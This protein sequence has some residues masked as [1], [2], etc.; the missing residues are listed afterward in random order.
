MRKF[1]KI[2]IPLLVL[3]LLVGV[4]AVMA[5]AE[6]V[7]QPTP[8]EINTSA[9]GTQNTNGA[10]RPTSTNNS[11]VVGDST[12]NY[13]LWQWNGFTDCNASIWSNS[14]KD[15]VTTDGSQYIYNTRYVVWSID[16]STASEMPAEF[17][18]HGK[19][20]TWS[21]PDA[22][23]AGATGWYGAQN[24]KTAELFPNAK[25]YEWHN[26]AVVLDT[27][28]NAITA[29]ADGNAVRTW[30][31]VKN[32]IFA[33]TNIQ[34][35][36]VNWRS[37][38]AGTSLAY[39]NSVTAT[40]SD[41]SAMLA[42]LA[43]GTYDSFADADFTN[44]GHVV[45][46][47]K[48]LSTEM[49][50]VKWY[51]PDGTVL[52]AETQVEKGGVAIDPIGI[53]T[54]ATEAN[55]TTA[56]TNF[57][58]NAD[59]NLYTTT[60]LKMTDSQGAVTFYGAET[61]DLHSV[62]YNAAVNATA[63][64]FVNVNLASDDALN[65][66]NGVTVRLWGV[67]LTSNKSD[68]IT[69]GN[70]FTFEGV[71]TAD[72]KR[73]TF[74]STVR[75]F[76][77]QSANCRPTF[78]NLHINFKDIRVGDLRNGTYTFENCA[79]DLGANGY[80]DGG[81]YQSNKQQVKWFFIDS[82]VRV[83]GS[84]TPFQLSG[85]GQYY[86]PQLYLLGKTHIQT[87]SYTFQ[88]D[89]SYTPAEDGVNDALI[90][91]GKDVT[92]G[93]AGTHMFNTSTAYTKLI[94][95]KGAWV[96]RDPAV[97]QS[98]ANVVFASQVNRDGTYVEAELPYT[99]SGQDKTMQAPSYDFDGD[100]VSDLTAQ[101]NS[102]RVLAPI[103]TKTNGTTITYYHTAATLAS[104][105]KSPANGD[106]FD[107]Y[108]DVTITAVELLA[109][110]S[111]KSVTVN[112]HGITLTYSGN[113]RLLACSGNV[114]IQGINVDGKKAKID[115][116]RA[117]D[118]MMPGV[119]DYVLNLKNLDIDL[120][121][122][123]CDWRGGTLNIDGCNLTNKAGSVVLQVYVRGTANIN[124]NI[125]GSTLYGTQTGSSGTIY[126]TRHADGTGNYTINIDNS[127]IK[128]ACN[129]AITIA[130]AKAGDAVNLGEKTN[131]II[132]DNGRAGFAGSGN[133][134]ITIAEG[135]KYGTNAI[136]SASTTLPDG[137]AGLF[138]P[139]EDGMFVYTSA[140]NPN[141]V[142]IV[143]ND[144]GSA[145]TAGL[146]ATVTAAELVANSGTIKFFKDVTVEA[147][148]T[149]SVEKD[150]IFNLNGTTMTFVGL[151][152][153]KD[154]TNRYN[155]RNGHSLAF[156]NGTVD[157][158][159]LGDNL[160]NAQ[161]GHIANLTFDGVK[162]YVAST[163]TDFRASG[164]IT[165]KDSQITTSQKAGNVFTLARG[166]NAK[167]KV[168]VDGSTIVSTNEEFRAPIFTASV[169]ATFNL[170]IT[171]DNSTIDAGRGVPFAAGNE[172][173]TYVDS[174][175]NITV[176][177][178]WI[179]SGSTVLVNGGSDDYRTTI[180]LGEG[181]YANR[182]AVDRSIDLAI[183]KGYMLADSDLEGYDYMVA[184]KIDVVIKANL[185]LYNTITFNVY[186]PT[187]L[188]SINGIARESL[189]M[190]DLDKDGVDDHYKFEVVNL[191]ADAAAAKIAINAVFDVN[192]TNYYLNTN[193]SVVNY[194]VQA[195]NSATS[196]ESRNLTA[197]VARYIENAYLF[198]GK[199]TTELDA[200]LTN[201]NYVEYVKTLTDLD[202]NVTGEKLNIGNITDAF[203]NVTFNL[204]EGVKVRFT[205][206]SEYNGTFKIN[207]ESYTVENGMYGDYNFVEIDI[208]AFDF[209]RNGL[210][211]T[212]DVS[213]AWNIHNYIAG[214]GDQYTGETKTL[215]NA[216]Y[217]YCEA[218][219]VYKTLQQQN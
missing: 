71:T 27:T 189:E 151:A 49:C 109:V 7:E 165:I 208:R 146:N 81:W 3:A 58:V 75:L 138:I 82:I 176:N 32:P 26:F 168:D 215:V 43:N 136:S 210:R 101:T 4:F 114:T 125:T 83:T 33:L 85:R 182:K 39:T 37:F 153:G 19:A 174:Y 141:F 162:L 38:A 147:N 78:K 107:I 29:F 67:E 216:L 156:T 163:I 203:D 97:V 120:N 12:V 36:P 144:N 170:D 8:S 88:T 55:G 122:K 196:E 57:T 16:L 20:S 95:E 205:L 198:S 204:T 72:G 190:V 155:I 175:F 191:A 142:Y 173:E 209:A 17:K 150:V 99:F 113:G 13:T 89:K 86:M 123:L 149:T 41:E 188:V 5:F 192:G 157:A 111:E 164:T 76:N 84:T 11:Y 117:G 103:A 148:G 214:L 158:T 90:V 121:E 102:Y 15:V 131:F 79:I 96:L 178:S 14:F 145:I 60:H 140:N 98:K 143:Y 172:A 184:E 9:P 177:N 47:S 94:L 62:F 35:E 135:F 59:T 106:V 171:V 93:S 206:K 127:D 6:D 70:A 180:T 45:A 166:G 202:Q 10:G 18:V 34:I 80:F 73:G 63:D 24:F 187:N 56:V 199:E 105:L 161:N 30:T 207:G 186:L 104:A 108:E 46:P 50:T 211:I 197:N 152:T 119:S 42:G 132:E 115:S 134:A 181:T 44:N 100:G 129:N 53:G 137:T 167:V 118:L 179:K 193:T 61:T 124:F 159:A 23:A 112:L 65:F 77:V 212:G 64:I 74:T 110:G 22:E 169:I 213:G 52:L 160:A 69:N 54:W 91:I 195:I 87:A 116:T 218:A 51:N 40:Y 217:Y 2:L 130:S 128:T 139:A 25:A 194:L 21:A 68:A 219:N 1:S 201:A 48:P 200:I 92:F 154:A 28:N 31:L 183:A 133:L 185:T 126:A 66:N